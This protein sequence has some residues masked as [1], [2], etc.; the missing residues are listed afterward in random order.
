MK[1]LYGTETFPP[2]TECHRCTRR[3]VCVLVKKKKYSTGDRSTSKTGEEGEPLC[4]VHRDKVKS[5]TT[6]ELE[7][8]TFV[9]D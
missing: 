5:T 8:R 2:D 4:G 9:G 1:G 6:A 7:F 3:A